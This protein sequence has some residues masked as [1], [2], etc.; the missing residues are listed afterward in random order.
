M[1]RA[2]FSL[3]FSPYISLEDY[4][5]SFLPFV[6]KYKSYIH[7]IF[8]TIRIEP[9]TN[10][11]MGGNFDPNSLILKALKVQ[12]DTGIPVSATFNDT[13]VTAT[14]EELT[15]FIKNFRPLYEAGMHSATI[16]IFHWMLSGRIK[17]EFPNLKIKNSVLHEVDNAQSYWLA[18]KAG[19]DI[20]NI[21][22][23]ILRSHHVLAEIK[24]AQKHF[25]DEFGNA[26]KTQILA[27]EQCLPHCPVRN[28]HYGINFTGKHYFGDAVSQLSCTTWE[29]EDKAYDFKRAVV[30]P[31]REDVDDILQNVDIFKLFGRDGTTMIKASMALIES[32]ANKDEILPTFGNFNVLKE[33]ERKEFDVWRK[34]IKN[35]RFQCWNCHVCDGLVH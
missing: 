1:D 22:R 23:N 6:L 9:F 33:R 21:D 10:D 26:P 12:K 20:V 14:Y 29:K 8:C 7:D 18:A 19:Y 13:S 17:K 35:C 5:S 28:E 30:S 2:I 31:F 4:E 3:P 34:T 11:A 27:N 32:Y 25:E 15:L 16:P 24:K